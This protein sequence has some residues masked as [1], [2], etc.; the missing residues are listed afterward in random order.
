MTDSFLK[1]AWADHSRLWEKNI[2]VYPVISRRAKG[3]SIGVNLNPDKH[4]SFSCVYCQVDRSIPGPTNAL[5]IDAL[6]QELELIIQEYQKNGLTSFGHFKEIDQSKR[7]IKDIS[8]SG[9]G[10]STLV[11]E[12]AAVCE[13]LL[14]IQKKYSQ[15]PLKLTLITNSTRLDQ[16]RVRE[17][18]RFLTELNGEIWA[19][20]DAGSEEWFQKVNVSPYSLNKVQQ[21]IELTVRDFPTRIQSMWCQV[22]GMLPS[23]EEIDLYVK[24]V[25]AIYKCSPENLL[26]VQLYSVVR[27]TACPNVLPVPEEFLQEV[28][29]KLADEIPT[30]TGIY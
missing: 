23:S 6:T 27:Y 21:N 13:R 26:E 14:E 4:C 10:E 7:Q 11:P 3:L 12:F 25:K 18:L 29:L 5:D 15:Y 24:R 16:E 8:L 28:A 17:G 19:K 22:D 1:E 2:W 30:P 20:L 9:D